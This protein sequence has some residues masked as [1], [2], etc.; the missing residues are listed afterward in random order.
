MISFGFFSYNL[1][2]I[3]NAIIYDYKY[4][5]KQFVNIEVQN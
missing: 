3:R 2:L 5:E 4:L 1:A